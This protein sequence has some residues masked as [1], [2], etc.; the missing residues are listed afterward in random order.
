MFPALGFGAQLPPDWKVSVTDPASFGGG[1]IG[2]DIE[3]GVGVGIQVS[4]CCALIPDCTYVSCTS[5]RE[6]RRQAEDGLELRTTIQL[7]VR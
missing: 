1:G 2:V 3:S 5:V 4:V 6:S 7:W